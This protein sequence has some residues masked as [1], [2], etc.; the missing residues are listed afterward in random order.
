MFDKFSLTTVDEHGRVEYK[1]SISLTIDIL[2]LIL[3]LI[4]G[5][6]GLCYFEVGTGNINNVEDCVWTMFMIITTIGF[7]DH[8]PET[9]GGRFI[10]VIGFVRGVV[11]YASLFDSVKRIKADKRDNG[12][13]NRQIYS[14]VAELLR[15]NQHWDSNK[16]I[17]KNSHS[18]DN[19]F[20]QERYSSD[21]L[22]EGWITAGRDSGGMYVISINAYCRN[23]DTAFNKWIPVDTKEHQKPLFDRI[24][25]NKQD[26]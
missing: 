1:P 2:N 13:S 10:A 11:V 17:D 5:S 6:F 3:V 19:V 21:N 16:T 12:I 20:Y 25:N 9:T 8:F 15:I 23:N 14:T 18:L 4:V 24:L 7:G 22:R 26:F